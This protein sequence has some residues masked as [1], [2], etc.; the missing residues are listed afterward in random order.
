MRAGNAVDVA[1]MVKFDG[2]GGQDVKRVL[3][4]NSTSRGLLEKRKKLADL[5]PFVLLYNQL[6]VSTAIVAPGYT[7][8]LATRKTLVA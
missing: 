1:E 7:V 6:I 5:V 2:I 3:S 4:C 8:Q